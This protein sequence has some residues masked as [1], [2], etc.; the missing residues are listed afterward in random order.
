MARKADFSHENYERKEKLKVGSDRNFG[1]VFAVVFFVISVSP[2]ILSIKGRA[3]FM[4]LSICFF[5][6]ALLNP[7]KL[8]RLNLYWAK[9]GLLLGIIISPIILGVLFFLAFLPT[10]VVLKLFKKD[11][12]SL[13]IEKSRLSYWISSPK[14][15]D[16]SM[17][18][19]F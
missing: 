15:I 16:S 8:H 4:V 18:D 1:L 6:A 14:S 12:L 19:Q 17:R 3:L 10:G 13:K 7:E 2:L 11:I 9:F 5:S